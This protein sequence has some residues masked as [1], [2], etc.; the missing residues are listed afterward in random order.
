MKQTIRLTEGELHRLI[1][2]CINE[3][4]AEDKDRFSWQNYAAAAKEAERRG[5]KRKD[6]FLNAATNSL[7][8]KFPNRH[9]CATGYPAGKDNPHSMPDFHEEGWFNPYLSTKYGYMNANIDADNCA[10]YPHFDLK[11]EYHKSF[12]D[13]GVKGW[14]K[15]RDNYGQYDKITEPS[16]IITANDTWDVKTHKGSHQGD[17]Y[18]PTDNEGEWD[19]NAM[20]D[21]MENYYTGKSHY[22]K[23]KGEWVVD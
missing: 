14:G 18:T 11:G 22:D 7:K 8:N 1:K 9:Y 21:D 3:A 15:S 13:R 6:A 10:F 16:S 12:G 4:I 23:N 2:S 17:W 19:W 5:D 20:S